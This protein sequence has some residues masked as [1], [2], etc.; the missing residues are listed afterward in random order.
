ML[1]R[2]LR[3][4]VDVIV[5]LVFITIVYAGGWQA[6]VFG[7]VQRG[8]L[9]IGFFDAAPQDKIEKKPVRLDF[10]LYD[11]EG[12]VIEVSQLRGKT[13][14]IN[15]WASWCPPCI[16]EMPGIN[17]LY[18]QLKDDPNIKFLMI[19][20]DEEQKKALELHHRKEFDF[21]IYFPASRLPDALSYQSIPS[22]FVISPEGYIVYQKEGMASYNH[23]SFQN[24]LNGL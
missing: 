3:K 23:P 11:Q 17:K 21:P 24:F 7:F 14:F 18:Q 13:I 1:K 6:E 12:N 15:I 4:N 5:F 2:K 22:T 10:K 9:A 19:S 8:I 16:A 20:V